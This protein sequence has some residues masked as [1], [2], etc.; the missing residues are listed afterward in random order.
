ML[1]KIPWQVKFGSLLL[2]LSGAIYL[3]HYFI[4]R[5]VHHLVIY[6]LHELAFIPIE[7]LIVTMIL[8][9]VLE[10][11]E[12]KERAHKMNMVIGAFFSEVGRD[13]L[14]A[15]TPLCIDVEQVQKKYMVS[16][17]WKERDFSRAFKGLERHVIE[18][19]F[20]KK[21]M[22]KLGDL[23]VNKRSFLLRLLENSNLLEHE[24][25]TNLLWATFHLTEELQHRKEKFG[26]TE[27]DIKHLI[28]DMNRVYT[29]L[30]CEWLLYM[31][32]L[33]V[34][35]PYLFSLAVRTNPF[36]DQADI[37]L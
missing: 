9:G 12:K 31:K 36:D 29:R 26:R 8:H 4:F 27:E 6:S 23:L 19:I 17:E 37:A 1:K 16:T 22:S 7:V 32:H 20:V 25:F 11:R 35:Y 24:S 2:I 14:E 30:V 34:E 5:D 10:K 3:I 33:K 18:L 13:L 15:M 21:E 28:G